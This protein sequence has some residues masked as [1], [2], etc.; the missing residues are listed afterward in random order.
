LLPAAIQGIPAAEEALIAF[1]APVGPNAQLFL[2]DD[3]KKEVFA[4]PGAGKGINSASLYLPGQYLFVRDGQLFLYEASGE[5]V[6]LLAPT[7]SLVGF[8]FSPVPDLFGNVYFL[9][10]DLPEEALLGIGKLY[11]TS[12]L[13]PLVPDPPKLL[14]PG[15][16]LELGK[17]NSLEEGGIRSF[18]VTL[19]SSKLVFTTAEGGLYLYTPLKPSLQRLPIGGRKAAIASIDPIWGR[20]VVWKESKSN[21]L[22]S[23]DLTTRCLE[24]LSFAE[25]AESFVDIA[26]LGFLGTDPWH[27]FFVGM[28][29]S[30]IRFRIFSYDLRDGKVRNYS[31][32]GD[33]PAEIP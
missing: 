5:R 23:L 18:K 11:V 7:L 32:I 10:T 27:I 13:K 3:L 1:W 4:L 33:I 8:A 29:A 22:F 6:C 15:A 24:P 2:Y 26:A 14:E 30:P 21:R 28:L 19:D 16:I 17:V 9:G 20:Y 31:T 25:Q 12:A